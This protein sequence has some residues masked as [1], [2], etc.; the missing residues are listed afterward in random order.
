MA[1]VNALATMSAS[2]NP[3]STFESG[4]TTLSRKSFQPQVFAQ[5]WP[6][7]LRNRHAKAIKR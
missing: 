3:G 7:V 6:E 1:F 4:N 2:C 5:M